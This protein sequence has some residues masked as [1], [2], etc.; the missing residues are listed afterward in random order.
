MK[1]IIIVI[2]QSA[3]GKTTFIKNNFIKK[4]IT[5]YT[6]KKLV[7]L[8]KCGNI[9]LI[10]HYNIGKRCEGSD[11]LSYASLPKLIEFIPE[12]IN[13]CDYLVLDGDRISSI[14]FFNYIASLN[15][16]VDLYFLK[17]SIEESIKRRINNGSKGSEKF[18]RTTITKAENM[19]NYANSLGF[20]I[21]KINT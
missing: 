15:I 20:N 17:C 4:E 16:P 10:G 3:S 13:E 11:T 7:K 19:K 12:I 1:K 2:G 8:C 21:I 6:P 5:N 18:V 14:K 9:I